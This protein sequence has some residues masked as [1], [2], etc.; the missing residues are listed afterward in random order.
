MAA[1]RVFQLGG[2][3]TYINPILKKE[4]E[5]IHCVNMISDPFGAKTKRSG[6][7][8]YLGTANGGTVID[9][10]SWTND[11]GSL[12]VYSNFGGTLY[13]STGGT[14]EWAAVGNGTLTAGNHVGYTVLN[15]TLILGDGAGSTRHTTNGTS[16]TN[17]T[18][19]PVGRHF[20]EYQKRVCVGG[21]ASTL[22]YSTSNDA[23]NWNTSGTSDSSSLQITGAG[24]INGI[25]K[26]A[27]RLNVYKSSG[28]VKRWDGFSLVEL[29]TNSAPSSPYSIAMKEGYQFG[30]N[31]DGIVG[32]G[33]DRFKLLSNAITSQIYNNL[34]SAIVGSD[35]DTLPATCHHYDYFIT[36]GTSVTD[37]FTRYTMINNVIKYDYLKNEFLNWSLA[38]YPTSWHSYKDL[39]GDQ[40]LIFGSNNGQCFKFVGTATTD[41]GTPISCSLEYVIDMTQ[42]ENDK[43]WRWLWIFTNPGCQAKCQV[44]FEDTFR[45]DSKKWIEIG[46]MSAGVTEFRIPTDANARSKLMF[47]KFYESSKDAPFTLYGFTIDADIET[48]K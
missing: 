42:P 19:A 26:V 38:N 21:T 30:L 33:G 18:L 40:Q 20:A 9:L 14:A 47:I 11:S 28:E 43:L 12:F 34:G 25:S 46:D 44:A 31:R 27:D 15:N 48:R 22:F 32:Y 24:V 13:Q 8:S 41:N 29:A 45:R 36:A 10:F 39:T 5:S 23:T 2:I 37:G 6:Y 16:L 35:F 7:Q 3:N 4:G 17:T 1:Q